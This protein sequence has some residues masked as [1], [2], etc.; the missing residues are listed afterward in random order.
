[1][2]KEEVENSVESMEST[3]VVE[4]PKKVKIERSHAQKESQKK[5]T[6][7]SVEARRKKKQP[8]MIPLPNMEYLTTTAIVGCI[9]LGGYYYMKQGL[10]YKDWLPQPQIIEREVIKEVEVIKEIKVAVPVKPTPTPTPAPIPDLN[11]HKMN[12]FMSG[13]RELEI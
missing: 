5:A 9:A 12:E 2:E 10:N 8:V 3:V 4:K 7:K 6:A 13:S 1:M 11:T